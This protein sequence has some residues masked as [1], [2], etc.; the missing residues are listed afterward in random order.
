[1]AERRMFSK[2][3][4]DD[5]IFLSLSASA[6]ALYFH[7]TMNADD[8]GLCNQVTTSM[9]QAHAST[10]DLQALIEKKYIYQFESGV[11]AI[12]HWRMSNSLRKDRYTPTSHYEELSMLTTD[13]N[14]AY[15]WLPDGCQMV[16]ERLP[17]DSIVKDSI[18]KYSIIVDNEDSCKNFIP[19]TVEEVERY[20]KERN[21]NIDAVYF[22]NYYETR[23]WMVGKSPMSSWK[24]AMV[25]WERNSQKYDTSFVQNKKLIDIEGFFENTR[26]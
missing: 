16:A 8:D 4:T 15:T 12:K 13:E 24:C 17:Q 23:G 9:Y 14:G 10:Q 1:M 18:V 21:N 20:C 5:D 11:V 3:I 25:A 26:G 22:V 19:P 2:K 7:L 6:Q